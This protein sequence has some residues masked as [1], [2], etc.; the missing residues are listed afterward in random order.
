MHTKKI[1]FL[2]TVQHQYRI[3]HTKAEEV[4][5]HKQLGARAQTHACLIIMS[6][7]LST[8]PLGM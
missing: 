2:L 3:A 8:H 5:I 6:L 1:L 7:H 4:M